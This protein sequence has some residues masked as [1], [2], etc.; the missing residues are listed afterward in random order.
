[1]K[2]AL[3][4]LALLLASCGGSATA[5]ST[6]V[7]PTTPQAIDIQI[8]TGLADAASIIQGLT[9]LVAQ[10]PGLKDPLNRAIAIYTTVKAAEVTYDA[11]VTAGGNPDPT[12]IKA[13]IQNL[14]ATVGTLQS[15]YGAKP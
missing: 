10:F 9:P 6:P 3:I 2:Y 8:A 4:A 14:L 12:Q 7:P 5:P 15:L 1:M 11:A 13:D